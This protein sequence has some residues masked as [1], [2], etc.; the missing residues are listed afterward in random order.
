M[1][2][3]TP[4]RSRR[5]AAILLVALA[6][7]CS[8]GGSSKSSGSNPPPPPPGLRSIRISWDANH[9]RGVNKTGGYYAVSTDNGG[10]YQYVDYTS[11]ALTP[12]F[13]DTVL[14]TGTYANSAVWACQAL[15]ANGGN[16]T[17]SCSAAK[18]FTLNVP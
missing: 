10:S 9:E 7:A 14:F 17:D 12:T 11:G 6:A 13:V 5:L 18:T 1:V 2:A 4:S 3:K 8:G 16:T 15:D